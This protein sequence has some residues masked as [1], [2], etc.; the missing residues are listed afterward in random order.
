MNQH[1]SHIAAIA[2]AHM[3]H[4]TKVIWPAM[5]ERSSFN[6]RYHPDAT[7]NMQ[8]WQYLDATSLWDMD[9]IVRNVRGALQ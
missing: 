7:K 9:L 1:Y 2:L 6:N 4:A 8:S 5:Q 3:T